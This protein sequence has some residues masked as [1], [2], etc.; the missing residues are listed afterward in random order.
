MKSKL[1]RLSSKSTACACV[2]RYQC[3]S[4][5]LLATPLHNSWI[6]ITAQRCCPVAVY[7]LAPCPSVSVT[8]RSSIETTERIEL[9][10][11]WELSSTYPTLCYKDIR[12]PLK[13]RVLPS[14]TLPELRT[15]KIFA[16]SSRSCGRRNCRRS[17]LWITPTTIDASLLDAHSLLHIG[18]L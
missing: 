6:I 5:S 3:K 8:S 13:I 11:A 2:A 18:R 1:Y 16:S 15:L 10:L 9:F 14:D 12:V 17:S 7:V 4:D